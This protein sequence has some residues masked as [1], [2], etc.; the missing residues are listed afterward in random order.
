MMAHKLTISERRVF[1][2]VVHTN[3][4]GVISCLLSLQVGIIKLKL[5]EISHVDFQ[6]GFYGIY[7]KVH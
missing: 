1:H 4:T 5:L 2:N 7:G 6:Q 3:T